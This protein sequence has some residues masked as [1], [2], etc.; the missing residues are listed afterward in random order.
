MGTRGVE[1]GP[2]AG[3]P[4]GVA[5]GRWRFG[6][7]RRL[8]AVFTIV[9]AA[10]ASYAGL[11][12]VGLRRMAA[13]FDAMEEHEHQETLALALGEAVRAQYGEAGGFV[14]RRTADLVEYQEARAR[15]VQLVDA[16]IDRVDEPECVA[17]LKEI[18][19]AI[20]GLDAVFQE[21]IVPAVERGDPGASAAHVRG[22][23]FV[24]A[25]DSDVNKLLDRLQAGTGMFRQQLLALQVAARRWA[26]VFF[27][28]G[29]LLILAAVLY[30]SRSVARPLARL[31]EGAAGVSRQGLDHRLEIDTPDEFGALAA[32][33]NAMTAALKVNQEKLVE[34]EKLA[35]IG[36]LA[37][38]VAHEINNPLQVMLG[39]LTLHR[40]VP[41]PI[42][43][44]D[45][46][47]VEQEVLRCKEIV[48]AL[49]ELSRPSVSLVAVDLRALCDDVVGCLDR[50]MSYGAVRVSVEGRALALGDPP[51]LRQVLLNLLKN[52]MEAAGPGGQV[53][54]D[55]AES[56]SEVEVTISDTGPGIAP[57]ARSRLFEPFFTTKPSG[58][59]LGLAVSQSIAL[60]HG[61]EVAIRNAESGGAVFTLRLPRA[62]PG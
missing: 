33:F 19:E 42:L 50:S 15:A 35:G 60:A 40:S 13:T 18:R 8:V 48:D 62:L 61:G 27:V 12:F 20:L 47:A 44:R 30:L 36:R 5:S 32:E 45:L 41:D 26:A 16:L 34:S 43:S 23:Q 14:A 55:L 49:L 52:A 6:T 54:T 57:D 17:W 3:D 21:R 58:T 51:K 53:R 28:A 39:Y 22:E 59:G 1:T 46:A 7:R 37:A 38:G 29:T 9:L 4:P 31:A 56:G 24:H 10:F 2:S 11:Q 25:V